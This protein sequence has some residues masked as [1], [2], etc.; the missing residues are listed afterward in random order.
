MKS[1]RLFAVVLLCALSAIAAHAQTVTI[2]A[3]VADYHWSAA[4][5]K[6]VGGICTIEQE[7][8]WSR[9]IGIDNSWCLWGNM[10]VDPAVSQKIRNRTFD[11]WSDWHIVVHNGTILQDGSARVYRYSPL[12]ADWLLFFDSGVDDLGAWTSLTA[13]A[14]D[15]TEVVT[16]M[17]VLSVYFVYNPINPELPITIDEWPTTDFVPEPSS[18]LALAGGL[19]ALGFSLRRK[20]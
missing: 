13:I 17:N 14:P 8:D 9:G 10:P 6:L 3:T 7:L 18:L 4:D 15:P 16:N 1:A 5:W 19:S 12:G 20:R 11:A 2:D